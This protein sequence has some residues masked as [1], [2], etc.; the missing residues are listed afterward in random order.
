MLVCLLD[1]LIVPAPRR[2]LGPSN[3]GRAVME[4]ECRY[5]IW[6]RGGEEACDETPL[7][8]RKQRGSARTSGFQDHR[9][10][11]G[12]GRERREV[13][14]RE[15]VRAAPT[16][17]VVDDQAREGSESL[18]HAS[19]ARALP[20]PLHVRCEAREVDEIH[21]PWPTT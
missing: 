18:Q 11:L 2:V 14:R 10:V 5:P 17:A 21:R 20:V 12:V 4:D 16:P 19:I 8:P 15:T 3:G 7:S 9:D 6:E 13:T 1:L